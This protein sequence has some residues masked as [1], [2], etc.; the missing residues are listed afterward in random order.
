MDSTYS[1][2]K[3]Y[4]ISI[5]VNPK[6]IKNFL[7]QI[8]DNWSNKEP[9]DPTPMA[10]YKRWHDQETNLL[11]LVEQL[12]SND[13]SKIFF[14]LNSIESPVLTIFTHFHSELERHYELAKENA[15]FLSTVTRY[16]KV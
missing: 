14:I 15:A 4:I 13:V 6:M 1:Q 10:E 9:E 3:F 8:T 5:A 7:L 2:S 11:G 12:K 16:F